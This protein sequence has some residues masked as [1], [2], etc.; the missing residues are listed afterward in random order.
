VEAGTATVGELTQSI[1]RHTRLKSVQTWIVGRLVYVRFCFSS[2]DANGMNMVTIATD[3]VARWIVANTGCELISLSS[4]V[5]ADKK[6]A[7][8]NV[9]FGLGKTVIAEAT[10]PPAMLKNVLHTTAKDI[11][12]LVV[13]KNLLGS[14]LSKLAEKPS[15]AD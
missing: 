8:V 10:I 14:L 12:E 5:C 15:R 1:S 6:P 13:A 2:G 7:A 3:T 9:L 11:E 4:N